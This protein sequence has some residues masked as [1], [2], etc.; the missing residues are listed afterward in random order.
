M[1]QKQTH[2]TSTVPLKEDPLGGNSVIPVV[3]TGLKYFRNAYQ[4]LPSVPAA[5]FLK[6]IQKW[7]VCSLMTGFDQKQLQ[8]GK[9]RGCSGQRIYFGNHMKC[10]VE[11]QLPLSMAPNMPQRYCNSS[12]QKS[13]LPNSVFQPNSSSCELWVAGGLRVSPPYSDSETQEPSILWLH[14]SLGF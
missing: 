13:K 11:P 6:H 2:Q 4:E 14:S 3:L 5:Q 9:Q 8:S 1:I 10:A 12:K 7:Q